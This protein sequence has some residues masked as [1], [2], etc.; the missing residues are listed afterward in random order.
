TVRDE[1]LAPWPRTEAIVRKELA[2]YHAAIMFLDAQVGRILDAL[3]ASGQW[4]NTL[5]VFSSDHGL[6]IGSH[7]LMGKQSLYEH[8][9]R[10]P[11]II[12][13]PGIGKGATKD[14]LCYLLDVY[15]TLGEL[16]GV[17]GPEGSEGLSLG[18]VLR[19]EETTRRAALMT[20][21]RDLQRAVRDDRYKLIVYP[22]INKHQLFDLVKDPQE[23]MDLALE[24]GH[25]DDIDRM[26][27]L[28]E[29]LQAENGD[30]LALRSEHPLPLAFDFTKVEPVKPRKVE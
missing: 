19:G 21:Y 2:D 18:P 9:M 24:P 22:K 12:A 5:I 11:L 1:R 20:G 29:K 10:S 27:R 30:A 14:A 6:A 15:P 25:T 4:E 13:G 3:K 8:S 26:T 16:A 17:T 23:M 28:L 7:G